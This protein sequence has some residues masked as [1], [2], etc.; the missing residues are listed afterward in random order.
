[1]TRRM[2]WTGHMAHIGEECMQGFSRKSGR[3]E[4][5]GG[6]RHGPDNNIKMERG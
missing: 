6:L 3:K 1:M 2:R 5:T 4:T